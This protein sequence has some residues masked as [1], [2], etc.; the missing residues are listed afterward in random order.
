MT[1]IHTIATTSVCMSQIS[2]L[3]SR[4]DGNIS[5]TFT[6]AVV[7]GLIIT[8]S[9]RKQRVTERIIAPTIRWWC[10]WRAEN[11]DVMGDAFSPELMSHRSWSFIPAW[12][13]LGQQERGWGSAEKKRWMTKIQ[14][15]PLESYSIHTAYCTWPLHYKEWAKSVQDQILISGIC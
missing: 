13:K 12:H 4:E 11:T 14:Y 7:C 1:H 10:S 6:S 3:S 15:L 9:N 2:I 5:P 8:R